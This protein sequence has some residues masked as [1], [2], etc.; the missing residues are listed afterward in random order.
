V[1]SARGWGALGVGS[2]RGKRRWVEKEGICGP[3]SVPCGCHGAG[4]GEGE[5]RQALSGC[6]AGCDWS[7]DRGGCDG[8]L[9]SAPR[10]RAV[11]AASGLD[12][13]PA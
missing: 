11:G 7:A 2:T 3:C 4:G 10:Q 5:L 8:A 9:R 12:E 1:L 6:W 13:G